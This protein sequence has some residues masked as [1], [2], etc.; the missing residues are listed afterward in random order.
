MAG[1]HRAIPNGSNI[2]GIKMNAA[3][4]ER[5]GG[6]TA[7]FL[8]SLRYRKSAG[9]FDNAAG[10]NLIGQK[11]RDE[12]MTLSGGMA[13]VDEEFLAPAG[14]EMGRQVHNHNAG[15]VDTVDGVDIGLFNSQGEIVGLQRRVEIDKG[16]R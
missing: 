7:M 5:I 3:E 16:E 15:G 12:A 10:E 2:T 11:F 9:G 4:K 14:A 8:K 1:G 6:E 13:V